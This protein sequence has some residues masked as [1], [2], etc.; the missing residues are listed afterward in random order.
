M[1]ITALL[2][3][4]AVFLTAA[5][6]AL[7]QT[8]VPAEMTA[9]PMAVGVV[10]LTHDHVGNI[11]NSEKRGDIKIV[12]IAEPDRA[13]AQKYADRYGFSMDIV[14]PDMA[15]MMD[16]THPVAVTGFDSIAEHVEIV[17]AAAPRGIHVMVEKPLAYSMKDADEMYGLAKKYHI[18]L[19]TNYETT[20]YPT[21]GQSKAMINAG[22]I[23][24]LRKMVFHD[25][26]QGPA[27]IGV[28]KE[29]LSWLTDPA[30]N[31]GGAI[32]DF[33]CYGANLMTWLTEGQRP[34]AVTAVTRHFQPETYPK[35]DDDATIVVDYPKAQGIAQASWDWPVGRKDME[36]YGTTGQIVTD[37]KHDMRVWGATPES[38]AAS[39]L[40]DRPYPFDDSNSYFR[41]V[42]EG[43]VTPPPYDPSSL[44]NNMLVVEI[45]DAARKSAATGK[46]VK[47]P[48]RP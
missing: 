31:G 20:W 17:R 32:I 6:P 7:S 15:A 28:S 35:V 1:R 44:E 12:G 14:Y 23:G 30:K 48:A 8:T 25:G 37:N 45:L 29:F 16:K 22:Q 3:G 43:R 39:T 21:L 42:I 11:F 24:T 27:T 46:T 2:L 13:L 36:V 38:V 47:L 26:H 33:G 19:L 41:A 9:Q 40:P 34:V 5:E 18:Q 10:G 4:A